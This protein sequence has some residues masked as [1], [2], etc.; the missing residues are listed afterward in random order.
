M[1]RCILLIVSVLFLSCKTTAPNSDEPNLGISLPKGFK[2]SIY[3]ENV[4]E[5]R[6]MALGD[7]GTLF[8]G[9]RKKGNVY[10]VVDTNGD[11][12]ADKVYTLAKN[13]KQPAGVAFR[14]GSLYYSAIG[15]I[16]RMDNIEANLE[17]PP[18]PVLVT[19]RF[20]TAEHHGWKYIAFGPDGKLYVPVGA[21]CNI[22]EE[23]DS[24]FA[25]IAR[26][27]PD[28]SNL[29]IIAH[30][31]RNTVGFDWH[32]QTGELWF[33]ENGTDWMGDDVPPCELNRLAQVG[34]HYGYPYCHGDD[35]KHKDFSAGKNCDDYTKPVQ[36]LGPHVAPLGMLFY[37]G[38]MFPAEY[39]NQVLIAEHGSWNRST[40][41]GYRVTMVKLNG[42]ESAG[43]S[44][45]ATGWLRGGDDVIGRPVDLVQM[46][47]GSV[48]L[49]DDYANMIYRIT[50]E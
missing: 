17:N 18:A 40:K 23:E 41:I 31:V 50:Y 19:D 9:S 34:Q 15:S 26:M 3:A 25:T 30:G 45:F 32:P 11:F 28:G 13:V 48:L 20:P 8:V 4:P 7:N 16:Y 1:T 46:K 39:R 49:S 37:T 24:I 27:D 36:N 5:A 44:D 38:S 42:N 29:E 47:D 43:Y 21:P 12:K 22:C 14:D 33:T 35:I 6:G 10:A 2:I